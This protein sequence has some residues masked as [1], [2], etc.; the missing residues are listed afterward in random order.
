MNHLHVKYLLVGG[1]LASSSA[2]QAIREIDREGSILLV[3]QEVNRPY[4]RPPLTKDYLRRQKS[5]SELFTQSPDWFETS[6]IQLRTGRRVSHLDVPRMAAILD[7]GED[8]SCDRLLI[9]TGAVPTLLQVPGSTLPN[10][11]YLRTLDD[12]EVLHHAIDKAKSEGRPHERGRGKVAVIGGGLLGVEVAASL[13][14]MGLAVDLLLSADCP[15]DRFAGENTGRF[16]SLFMEKRGVHVHPASAPRRLEGDGRVQRVVLPDGSSIDCDFAIA[17]V[18][19]TANME[20]LHG[21][22]IT[23]GRAI[24]TDEHCQT[25][26]PG[27][28]AAG[29]CAAL[30]DPLFGK[31]RVLDHWDNAIV[32]GTL[33]GRNMAGANDTYSTVNYFFSDV[34]ELALSAWGDSRH[35]DRRLL[36]GTPNVDAPDFIELGIGADDRIVQVLAIGHT[37]EDEL[38]RDLVGKRLKV[39]G[40]EELLKDPKSDLKKLLNAEC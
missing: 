1:G 34:F 37:G 11:F 8:V 29:D 32:T 17:A 15:W 35:I 2:A 31:H 24:L 6:H 25:N 10:L 38:L 3:A 20:L 18:G 19:A 30:F 33:A 39:N 16:L 4:H 21:T 36:R 14:Q 26:V 23:A 27:I 9:A 5:R 7:N 12:A 28:Y 22:P 40:N 13:T